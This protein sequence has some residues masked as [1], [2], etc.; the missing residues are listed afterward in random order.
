MM[1][2]IIMYFDAAAAF[3]KW[4]ESIQQFTPHILGALIM[5]IIGS[6]AY[7]GALKIG[8]TGGEQREWLLK[9]FGGAARIAGFTIIGGSVAVAFQL[10]E[11]SSFV[12]IQ[13]FVLGVTWPFIVA[14]YVTRV[15]KQNI[16]DL[17]AQLRKKVEI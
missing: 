14:Q 5:G 15:E 10:P 1:E 16:E 11:P 4:F 2:N 8:F 9:N 17:L 13:A 7:Y 3:A 12:P 6:V